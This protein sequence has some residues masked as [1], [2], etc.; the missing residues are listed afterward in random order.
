MEKE[1][2]KPRVLPQPPHKPELV[3]PIIANGTIHFPGQNSQ[4]IHTDGIVT[5][6]NGSYTGRPVD[7]GVPVQDVDDL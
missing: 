7:G 3:D 1:R 5:D 2:E 4:A 6:P